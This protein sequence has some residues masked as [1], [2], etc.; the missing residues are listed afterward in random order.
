VD[1]VVASLPEA[2]EEATVIPKG[3]VT[4]AERASICVAIDLLKIL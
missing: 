3:V 1:V 4:E 2:E